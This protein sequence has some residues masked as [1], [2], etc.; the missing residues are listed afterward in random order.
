VNLREENAEL[1]RIL[2]EACE[3]IGNA[4]RMSET[5]SVEFMAYLPEEIRLHVASLKRKALDV[6]T[7]SRAWGDT[8]FDCCQ[9]G[10]REFKAALVL[11]G[12]LDRPCC[13]GTCLQRER[14]RRSVGNLHVGSNHMLVDR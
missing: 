11:P 13:S 6:T 12:G 4:S 7:S 8:W 5:C 2:S 14:E 10:L 1:R 9:C 3:A